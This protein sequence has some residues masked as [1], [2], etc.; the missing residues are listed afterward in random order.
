MR[1][2]A[3][4]G[5]LA[6]ALVASGALLLTLASNLTFV[7]DGWE[8][9]AGRP[10]WTAG[11]FLRPFNEHPIMLLALVYKVLLALFG[12]ESALPFY[13]VSISLFLGSAVLLFVYMRRR[14][15]PWGAL[16]GAVLVLFMGAAWEDL[17]WEFQMCFFGSMAAGLGALLALDREDDA[18]DRLACLLLVIANASSSLGVPFIFAVTAKLALGPR[19]IRWRRA[20]VV[21]LPLGLYAIWW[22]GTGH[23]AG[24]RI[25]PGDIPD[26]PR[27]MFDAAAAGIASLLGQQ[28]IAGD[29]GPPPLA[30]L[31][32]LL[33]T[34]VLA[35]RI[36]RE[37][38]LSPGL[39]VALVLVFS[40]WGLLAIDRGPQRFSSRFQYPS[41]VFLLIVA[42]EA[43]RGQRFPRWAVS[44]LAVVV[45]AAVVGGIS[46]LDQGYEFRKST[47]Q[48]TKASLAAIE[49]AG[50]NA[51][52]LYR[53]AF[54]P[55]IYL[56]VQKYRKAA[57]EHGTPAFSE[58]E[59]MAAPESQRQ[60]ADITLAAATR[61]RLE[62]AR[63]SDRA[64][65][66]RQIRPAGDGSAEGPLAPTGR[67][68][69]DN[70]G[71]EQAI[72]ALGRFART[73]SAQ[74]GVLP[75]GAS[76]SLYLPRD[77][78]SRPWRL[79]ARGATIR[80]CAIG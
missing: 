43:L 77:R 14:V 51:D 57:R 29:G 22:L 47:S 56:K 31:L 72:L 34:A 39:I 24:H 64:G 45:V 69:I 12:M 40:F 23:A 6:L 55:S 75:G 67:F 28:P 79:D 10:D 17:L 8:L 20:Y 30:Q 54:V 35:Y 78:S 58:A 65:R 59:L 4:I 73:G 9:L 37:R 11:T 70:R 19:P 5:L 33:L 15:G 62:P 66:C 76:R 50:A 46:L 71:E 32:A 2:R 60:V 41:A 63:H 42:A 80:V 1:E 74:L 52:P 53:I 16:A 38:R 18:G 25:G 61:L 49:I 21:L 44:V 3:P 26:F 13:L 27:Y 68:A 48:S 36:Y 7:S